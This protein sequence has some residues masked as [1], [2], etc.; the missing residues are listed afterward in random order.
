MLIT[1]IMT[2]FVIRYGWKYPWSLVLAA[3]GFFFLVDFALLRANIVKVLD[4]GW[5]PLLIG[6]VMFTLMMTWK[7]GRK[8]MSNALRDE[9]IDLQ[10]LPRSR[11]SSARR[12]G[13]RARRSSWSAT[14]A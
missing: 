13:C 9:A 7:Q 3:T 10:Q 1:T 14:R 12:R 2:F 4:G 8:L 11:S 6:A 5:F